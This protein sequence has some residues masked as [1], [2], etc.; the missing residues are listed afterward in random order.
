MSVNTVLCLETQYGLVLCLVLMSLLSLKYDSQCV[1][2]SCYI[3][4][5]VLHMLHIVLWCFVL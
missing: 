1:V 3:V 4:H 5:I 2:V